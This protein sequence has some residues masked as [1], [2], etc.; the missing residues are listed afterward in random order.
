MSE[1]ALLHRLFE[2]KLADGHF[3]ESKSILWIMHQEM[4]N[5]TTLR[6]EV[7]SSGYWLDPLNDVDAYMSNTPNRGLS[8]GTVH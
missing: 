5:K 2:D 7:I 1:T 8:T 4:L 6:L 3:P